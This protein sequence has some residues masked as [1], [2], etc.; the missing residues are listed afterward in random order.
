M[1]RKWK[2]GDRFVHTDGKTYEIVGHYSMSERTQEVDP[3]TGGTFGGF[4][5]MIP[6]ESVDDSEANDILDRLCDNFT[7]RELLG[8]LPDAQLKQLYNKAAALMEW[9]NE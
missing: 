1:K 5:S 7:S 8:M 6:P 3:E 2:V 4:Y 9:D